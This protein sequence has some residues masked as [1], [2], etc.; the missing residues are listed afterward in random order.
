V[1]NLLSCSLFQR[2]RGTPWAAA[3]L[4][5]VAC[6]GRPAAT[7]QRAEEVAARGATV[8]PFD[9]TKTRHRFEKAP[10]GGLQTVTAIDPADSAQIGLIRQHLAHEAARFTAGDYSDPRAIHGADMPGLAA[11]S[12][13]A[14][15]IWVTFT[16]LP[17]GGNIR[18][19]TRDPALVPA[20][21]R[22]FDAQTTDH[23]EHTP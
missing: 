22:W 9:L 14:S 1:A 12:K 3:A 23:A 19:T 13:G 8:M 17:N 11:L 21:H 20:L 10:D 16:P 4:L 6:S 18:Y 2:R 5:A 15:Q 7:P